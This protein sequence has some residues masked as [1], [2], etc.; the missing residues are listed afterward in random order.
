[1]QQKAFF[2]L[3]GFQYKIVYKKGIT[4]KAADA[5]SRRPQTSNSY[6]ISEVQPRWLDTV[7]EG[8]QN[9]DKAK[10]LL[11]ELSLQ[12]FN[13]QGYSLHSG[14]IRHKGRVWLGNNKEAHQAILLA[15][16]SSAVGG[17]SGVSATY[18]R[19]KQL[20][21]WPGMKGDVNKFVQA[22][23]VCQQAKNEH[24]RLPGR[25]QPLPIPKTAWHTVSMDF[26]EG[27]PRS[28]QFDTILVVV[29]KLTKFAHFI[30]LKHPFTTMT[31]AQA[32]M[33]NV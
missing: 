9:D 20:F 31:V 21:A 2:K 25:L 27:L 32:I 19:I 1:M 10:T 11:S 24:V 8:Y 16:H 12:G 17:H 28:G 7:V 3:M 6:A 14:V 26:I 30:P 4:N 18:T 15:L 29:D 13:N 5:L 22:C 33:D 23:T